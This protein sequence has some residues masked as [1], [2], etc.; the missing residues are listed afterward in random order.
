MPWIPQTKY[1]ETT[2]KE[3]IMAESVD[4]YLGDGELTTSNDDLR[5][6]LKKAFTGTIERALN[7][8]SKSDE[9]KKSVVF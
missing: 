3:D 5:S 8:Q 7:A 2:V 9:S 4:T 1:S 6:T